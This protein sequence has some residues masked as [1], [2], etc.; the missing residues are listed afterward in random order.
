VQ[1]VLQKKL[2]DE[3]DC[4]VAPHVHRRVLLVPDLA[5][6]PPPVRGRLHDEHPDVVEN[7]VWSAAPAQD[8]E[9]GLVQVEV[10]LAVA[11]A[12]ARVRDVALLPHGG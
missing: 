12:G 6:D 7:V 5:L 3:P 8:Q 4:L 10:R 11:R 2:S 9:V 1:Q